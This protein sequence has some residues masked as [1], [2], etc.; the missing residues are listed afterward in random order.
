MPWL[1]QA[2]V[3]RWASP[4]VIQPISGNRDTPSSRGRH[5]SEDERQQLATSTPLRPGSREVLVLGDLA[6]E[7]ALTSHVDAILAFPELIRHH[8]L[9]GCC[10]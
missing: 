7:T 1:V 2:A 4:S 10:L 9:G 6:S 8:L 3:R 5:D